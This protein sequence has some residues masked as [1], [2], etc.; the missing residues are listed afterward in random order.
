MTSSTDSGSDNEP[1]DDSVWSNLKTSRKF[2]GK[3][4]YKLIKYFK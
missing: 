1:I 2:D 3:L 4:N